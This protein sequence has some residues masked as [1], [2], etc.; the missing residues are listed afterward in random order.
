MFGSNK[1]TTYVGEVETIIGK[2]TIM[3]GNISGKG[4][5]RIDGQFEGD[6]NTTGNIV[7][8]ENAKVTAQC[9]A[10]NATIA[11]TIYGNV[12]ITEKL[13]LLPSAQ[14]IGDIKAGI[15][16]ISEGAVFKGA[17]EMRH[18]SEELVTK[19]NSAK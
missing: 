7:I 1:K 19:K 13:E 16:G 3:K 15:L 11:G 5:I 10:V 6:I 2:D 17:C 4:T 9:K 14:I 12:D 18:T 8:G